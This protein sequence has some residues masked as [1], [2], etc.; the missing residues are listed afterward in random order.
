MV[1]LS[2]SCWFQ[3]GFPI[4]Y[5]RFPFSTISCNRR[6]IRLIR[7]SINRS[8]SSIASRTS[9]S[10]RYPDW[11]SAPFHAVDFSLSLSLF[12][13]HCRSPSRILKAAGVSFRKI[14]AI[15]RARDLS[16]SLSLSLSFSL[17]PWND[18]SHC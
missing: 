14:C 4:W 3:N 18:T 17:S 5:F 12:L 8:L 15:A 9:K 16:L 1:C 2:T 13:L 10:L 6:L 7:M 11:S